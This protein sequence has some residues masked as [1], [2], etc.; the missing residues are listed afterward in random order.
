MV[1]GPRR[2][3][4]R[5]ARGVR[6]HLHHERRIEELI[7]LGGQE[8]VREMRILGEHVGGEVVVLVLT[9]EHQQVGEGLVRERP[10]VCDAASGRGG[11]VAGASA[12]LLGGRGGCGRKGGGRGVKEGGRTGW[13]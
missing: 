1:A 7:D 8:L 2:R 5:C 3:D 11:A 10:A 4:A 12:R 6:A 9:V 13:R